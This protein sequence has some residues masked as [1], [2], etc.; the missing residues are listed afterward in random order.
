MIH[1]SRS[2]ILTEHIAP[3]VIL[4]LAVL[5]HP[6]TSRSPMVTKMASI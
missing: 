6:T 4:I 3:A 1:L 2:I 5:M